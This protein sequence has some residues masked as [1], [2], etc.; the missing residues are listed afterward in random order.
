VQLGAKS[1]RY[2][3]FS[4]GYLPR[5]LRDRYRLSRRACAASRCRLNLLVDRRQRTGESM[6]RRRQHPNLYS[7]PMHLDCG[8]SPRA[9]VSLAAGVFLVD[10]AQDRELRSG[11]LSDHRGLLGLNGSITSSNSASGTEAL[12]S[13]ELSS[14]AHRPRRVHHAPVKEVI[15]FKVEIVPKRITVC[16][17]LPGAN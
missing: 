6:G 17:A 8:P 15:Q 7:P 5:A 2:D 11:G 4:D 14:M 12:P 3:D 1:R 13:Q 16:L 9:I 10:R